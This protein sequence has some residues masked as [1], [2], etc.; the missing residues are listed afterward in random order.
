MKSLVWFR[1]DLRTDDNPALKYAC[2][3]SNEVHCLYI[4]SP[5]QFKMHNEANCK[6]QFLIQ[7]LKSLEKSLS[8][9]NIPLTIVSSNGF[10]DVT[11]KILDIIKDRSITM[12]MHDVLGRCKFN[13]FSF[14]LI[15]LDS[16]VK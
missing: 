2:T 4:Y 10:Y 1:N 9:F 3:H 6:I 14:Y 11:N 12:K 15:F 8:K 13:L 5:E 16:Q 7:N